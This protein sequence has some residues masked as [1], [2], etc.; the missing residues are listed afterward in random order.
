[1]PIMAAGSGLPP[2]AYSNIISESGLIDPP[3]N[4]T[5]SMAFIA[6]TKTKTKI[7]IIVGDTKGSRILRNM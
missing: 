4:S 2:T 6:P 7:V 5:V 1:M 3:M